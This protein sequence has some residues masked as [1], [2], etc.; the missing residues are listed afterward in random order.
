MKSWGVEAEIAVLLFCVA[1]PLALAPLVYQHYRRYG[2][3]SGGPALVTALT[4][5]YACGVIAFTLFPLPETTE[6]FCTLRQ[7]I[8]YWRLQPLVSF[9]KAVEVYQR[10]GFPGILVEEKFLQL[11]FNVVLT[12]P[13][14]ILLVYR[15]RRGFL[16]T[17][18]AGLSLSLAIEITQG[19]AVYGIFGCPYRLAELDD[20]MTNTMGASLG[21]LAGRAL[22]PWLP[23]LDW[24]RRADAGPPGLGRRGGAL[25]LDALALTIVAAAVEIVVAVEVLDLFGI[26]A[27][28]TGWVLDLAFVIGVMLPAGLLF[29]AL[30]LL[31]RDRATIGQVCTWLANT[32]PDGASLGRRGVVTRFAVRWLVWLGLVIMA[33][34]YAFPAVLAYEAATVLVRRDRRSLS[35][36]LAGSWTTTRRG[37]EAR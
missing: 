36:V 27:L 34:R 30:P 7:D 22:L 21:W 31:R 32:G 16:F 35:G 24:D 28:Q 13:L 1:F 2:R 8:A 33:P 29:L 17:T 5:F 23:S 20:L 37:L 6:A 4:W 3:F 26:A 11:F 9:G 25:L 10:V 14:G 19:T 12:L 18:A 15:Y